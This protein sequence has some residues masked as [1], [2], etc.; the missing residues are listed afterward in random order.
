[1]T[2]NCVAMVLRNGT[3]VRE[4]P[5]QVPAGIAKRR[6]LLTNSVAAS[7]SWVRNLPVGL[8]TFLAPPAVHVRSRL[9]WGNNVN[10]H[11]LIVD[12]AKESR[13]IFPAR[14]S[15]KRGARRSPKKSL[16]VLKALD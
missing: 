10:F 7:K 8:G 2:R 14:R 4:I 6:R 1:M 9:P 16:I 11:F 3:T 12:S 15:G 13:E 5:D